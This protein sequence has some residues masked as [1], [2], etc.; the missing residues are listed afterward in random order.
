MGQCR[1]PLGVQE[2]MPTGVNLNPH[3][4]P[5]SCTRWHSDNESLFG[6]QNSPELI[7]SLS[8]GNSVEFKVRRRAP[9][10]VPS[11]VRL[12]HGDI[13]VMDGL[14]QLESAHRTVS[15]LQGSRVNLT[16]R[17]VAQHIASCPLAGVVGCVLPSCVQGLAEP[18]SRGLG[19]EG[20]NKWIS[21]WGLVLLLSVLVFY[22]L[23]NTWFTSGGASSQ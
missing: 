12:D 1:T 3:A 20:E 8:L 7:V 18:D 10:E 14:A 11:S 15:G 2:G 21:F 5:R 4:G 9:G 13:L 6:P 16:F 22:L 19:V 23:V 17:W